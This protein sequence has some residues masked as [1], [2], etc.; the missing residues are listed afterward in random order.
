MEARPLLDFSA[1]YVQRALHLMPKQGDDAPWM[2]SSSY[3]TDVKLLR[4]ES[5]LDPNLR[6]GASRQITA[7]SAVA[8]P[9]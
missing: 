6:F 2:M 7:A 8:A 4:S 1:G 3:Y 5:V 9:A